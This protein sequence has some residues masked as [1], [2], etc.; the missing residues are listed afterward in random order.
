MA[1]IIT[2]VLSSKFPSESN[3]DLPLSHGCP[4]LADFY[5]LKM[6]AISFSETSVHTRTTQRHIPENGILQLL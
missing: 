1:A 3:F 5:T 2:R 4:S 6:G